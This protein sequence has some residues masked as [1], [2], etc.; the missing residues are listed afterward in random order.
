MEMIPHGKV[1]AAAH[2]YNQY[3]GHGLHFWKYLGKRGNYCLQT[4][5]W[6]VTAEAASKID[7]LLS[8]YAEVLLKAWKCQN[9]TIHPTG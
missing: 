9:K 5:A 7:M 2:F 4:N 1:I 3:G 8:P 6:E